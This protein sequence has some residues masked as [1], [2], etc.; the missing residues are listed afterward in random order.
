M[1]VYTMK[2]LYKVLAVMFAMAL[3]LSTPYTAITSHAMGFNA[4]AGYVDNNGT[5]D[6]NPWDS[7]DGGVG[8]GSS[9]SGSS[10]TP[11]A[12]SYDSGSSDNGGSHD[13]GSHD[14][15]SSGNGNY[16]GGNGSTDNGSTGNGESSA[17]A[18]DPNDMTVSAVGGQPFR[19]VMNKEHTAYDIYHCGIKRGKVIVTDTDGNPVAYQNIA[20]EQG[21]DGLNYVN[22]TFAEGV[23]TSKIS[24]SITETCASYLAQELGVS[25]L[26]V[27]GV[28]QM[29]VPTK[30]Y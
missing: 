6:G 10:S 24:V 27:N 4:D 11:S 5:C 13:S 19:I 21:D 18:K 22:I 23:D 26:K 14:S 29:S 12:P 15:G 2:R 17:P 16:D 30:K 3:V 9:D 28:V 25:G 8:G 20:V 1:E 7:H